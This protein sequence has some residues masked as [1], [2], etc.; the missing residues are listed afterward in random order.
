MAEKMTE[1]NAMEAFVEEIGGD[2]S[3]LKDVDV[4][5][6][7]WCVRNDVEIVNEQHDSAPDGVEVFQGSDYDL[8][9]LIEDNRADAWYWWYCFPGCLPDSDPFGPF[10]SEQEAID[11]AWETEEEDEEEDEAYQAEETENEWLLGLTVDQLK[12]EFD[13]ALD[14][15]NVALLRLLFEEAISRID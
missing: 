6:E 1:E 15:R 4:L 2:L 12:A 13:E 3:G 8:S 14:D 9:E 11:N 10:D 7:D 5:F